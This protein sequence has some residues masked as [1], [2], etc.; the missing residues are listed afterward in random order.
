MM[1]C[2]HNRRLRAIQRNLQ[3]NWHRFW[4]WVGV[5]GA[6]AI[7]A[8]SLLSA[9]VQV[10]DIIMENKWLHTEKAMDGFYLHDLWRQQTEQQKQGEVERIKQVEKWKKA[11]PKYAGIFNAR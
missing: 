6:T 2:S 11:N 1:P 9:W 10:N 4:L 5:I 7:L 8:L 3:W